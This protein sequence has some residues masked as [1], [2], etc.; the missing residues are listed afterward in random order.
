MPLPLFPTYASKVARLWQTIPL[1]PGCTITMRPGITFR[2]KEITPVAS[3]DATTFFPFPTRPLILVL[4]TVFPLP[5]CTGG[6]LFPV[7]RAL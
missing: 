4:K 6:P 3:P 1:V 7:A 5:P 2:V